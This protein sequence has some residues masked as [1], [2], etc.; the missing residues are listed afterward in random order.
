MARTEVSGKDRLSDLP[1]HLLCRIL[2]NLST[3]ESVRTSVLSPRWSNLW[4]LVSV[5]DLD[6]Q[7]FKG[8]HDMGEF[9]DSFME[10][11]EELGLKLKSFNM[12]Y[13]ANEHLHEPFVRRLNKVVRRG[14]CDLNIQNMVDVDVALVRMPPSLYSCATLVNLI[15]YC[16]VF[17][18]PRS[19]SVSLPS[20]KKMYFEGV[21]FDGD[22]VLET[23]IS[24]SPVLEELTVIPHPEDYLEVICVRSQS[25]E[26][27]R[28]ESKR[29]ECD[30]PKV[31]IDSPSLE[32]MSICDK[33]P[34]SLKIHRI[35]PFAEV[36]VDV[37]FDVEDDDPLEISKIR[38]F[39]VGL[40]TFHEL[41][42]SARTLE[43]I[44]DYSKVGPLPP[45]SNLF[46]LDASLVESSWEVLP[47]FLSC[48]MNLDSLV[49]ELDCV[50]EME[51][52]KLSPVPQCVLS[53][54]DFLQLKAPST[55]SKMKLA[56]YFRKKCTRLTKMLLSGQ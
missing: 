18:H 29:F 1:C 14:V 35:G 20:V 39:L 45:F 33:K 42:I 48:C 11:H 24:H 17:D 6:F 4:S 43:S 22:S 54:L 16:V 3:K 9:I 10:Y 28:L 27:F 23:L 50:P 55:P 2:S 5:L 38:K 46:G 19:K 53:S 49:I 13:D 44:H 25:L 41:T 51:E 26:S 52:I 21:K 30:N 36:T 7:D 12:F 37:E 32:F 31:E 34:E 40:S 47:A 8:E 56:T 15:L